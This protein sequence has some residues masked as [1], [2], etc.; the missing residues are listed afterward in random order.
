ML[1]FWLPKRLKSRQIGDKLPNLAAQK[2]LVARVTQFDW[3]ANLKLII[4]PVKL[5]VTCKSEFKY[6]VLLRLA[7]FLTFWRQNF[8]W[9]AS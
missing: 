1:K 6:A 5:G 7:T 8:D 4:K 9:A 3:S 2:T